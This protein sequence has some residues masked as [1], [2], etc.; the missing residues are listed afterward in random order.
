M[1]LGRWADR[2][3]LAVGI[4]SAFLVAVVLSLLLDWYLE[5]TGF[6]ERVDAIGA[7]SSVATVIPHVLR[8]APGCRRIGRRRSSSRG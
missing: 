7:A 3:L 5:P 2:H 1:R 8:P 4:G 6:D